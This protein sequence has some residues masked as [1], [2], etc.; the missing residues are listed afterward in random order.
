MELHQILIRPQEQSV[1]VLY[2]D[3]VGN[4]S[5]LVLEADKLPAVADLI[6]ACR[7]KLPPDSQ[8]PFREKITQEISALEQRLNQ[9]RQA[10]GNT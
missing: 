3:A 2:V 6:A 5:S 8:N 7:Q 4:R 1:I 9:L 10:V